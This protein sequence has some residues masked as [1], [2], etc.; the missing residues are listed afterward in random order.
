MAMGRSVEVEVP[1][2]DGATGG[3]EEGG[4]REAGVTRGNGEQQNFRQNVRM[5]MYLFDVV[6]IQPVNID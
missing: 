5:Y 4:G 3:S 2:V 6:G 1:M